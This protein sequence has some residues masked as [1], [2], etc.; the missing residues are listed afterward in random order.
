MDM[1]YYKIHESIILYVQDYA[2]RS[3]VLCF[4]VLENPINF[5]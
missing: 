2:P 1:K 5:L 3:G 4:C